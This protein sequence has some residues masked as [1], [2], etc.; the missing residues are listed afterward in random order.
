MQ[1]KIYYMQ[2][3]YGISTLVCT[4]LEKSLKVTEMASRM[5]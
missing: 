4:M 5:H 3:I 2:Q 1:T